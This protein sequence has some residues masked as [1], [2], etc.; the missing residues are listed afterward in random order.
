[1]VEEGVLRGSGEKIETRRGMDKPFIL[2][3]LIDSKEF[4]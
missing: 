1:V 3:Q 2:L 4:D